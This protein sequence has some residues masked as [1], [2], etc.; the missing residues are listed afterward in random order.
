M[1][2]FTWTIIIVR[3]THWQTLI[4]KSF[5]FN[6]LTS[7][8]VSIIL[9]FSWWCSCQLCAG[10]LESN[11]ALSKQISSWKSLQ[12]EDHLLSRYH[13]GKFWFIF[14]EF[15]MMI[16]KSE[17]IPWFLWLIPDFLNFL[18]KIYLSRFPGLYSHDIKFSIFCPVRLQWPQ[19]PVQV[20][21]DRE[22]QLQREIRRDQTSLGRM[23][24]DP[25]SI[26]L[27]DVMIDFGVLFTQ[28]NILFKNLRF[29]RDRDILGQRNF[30]LNFY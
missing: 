18:N 26:T 17:P 5:K 20:G 24:H 21:W 15:F 22:D 27:D 12:K 14:K 1:N 23:L 9:S 10:R 7:I 6:I 29:A 4:F 13:L 11:T 16:E 2:L 30:W 8:F 19:L 3:M 28:V 25:C